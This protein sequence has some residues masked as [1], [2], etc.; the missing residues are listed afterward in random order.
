MKTEIEFKTVIN[1]IGLDPFFV[2][3]HTGEQIHLYRNYARESKYP[4]IILDATGSV[5]SNFK[6]YDNEKTKYIFLYEALVYDQKNEFSFTI[7]NMLSERHSNVAIF[8]WLA[9]W[10]KSDV[11]LPKTTVCDQSLA[12]LSAVVQ[13]FTQYSSLQDY[14]NA[15]ADLIVNN[16]P[17]NKH[18]IPRCFVRTD[19]AHFLKLITKWPPLKTVARRVREVI[20]RSFCMLIK[21][22]CLESMCSLLLSLFIVLTN[23][24]DGT[25]KITRENTPCEIHKQKIIFVSATGLMDNESLLET[26]LDPENDEDIYIVQSQE[27]LNEALGSLNNPFQKLVEQ[28]Y[29]KSKS[30]LQTGDN[31]NPLYLPELVPYIIK[32]MK[33]VP[34]W[35]A[36]MV[37]IFGYGDE[38][39]SSAAVESSFKKLKNVTFKNISLPTDIELFLENHISSLRGMSLL[40]SSGCLLKD[41]EIHHNNQSQFNK[42]GSGLNVEIDTNK[43]GLHYANSGEQ[44]SPPYAESLTKISSPRYYSDTNSNKEISLKS[45]EES[46]AIKIS[47]PTYFTDSHSDENS[48]HSGEYDSNTSTINMDSDSILKCV[49]TDSLESPNYKKKIPVKDN[50]EK[51]IDNYIESI[52]TDFN[53]TNKTKKCPL[54]SVGDFPT[55]KSQKCAVCEDPVHTLSTC[56]VTRPGRSGSGTFIICLKCSIDVLFVDELTKENKSTESWNK[57]STNKKRIRSYLNPNPHLKYLELNNLK[58]M[59]TLPILKNGSRAEELKS[60]S[61]K[62]YGKIILSNTCAFDSAASILMVAYCDSINYNTVVDSSNSMFLKFIAEIVKNGISAKTYSNRAEIMVILYYIIK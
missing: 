1:D 62:D 4:Q 15:C 12:I 33:L 29:D 8:N 46:P 31:I 7:S 22:Q 43:E 14:I 23:E 34:L 45:Y 57:K 9:N 36:I 48:H 60:C 53:A 41:T 26:V 24:T 37:P 50:Y 32:C 13:C 47:S 61:M 6:K 28:I 44:K 38:T 10:K 39:V 2:H 25:D 11:P 18:W 21:S 5:V 58:K 17:A 51:K 27:N 3:Y 42:D 49:E 56:S 59:K 40:K 19:I 20:L 35:S 16:L 54:C 52:S 55:D 30:F